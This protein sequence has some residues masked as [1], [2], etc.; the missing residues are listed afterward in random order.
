MQAIGSLFVSYA[1]LLA[2]VPA[3]RAQNGPE[4]GGHE[5][6][7]WTT[8]GHGTNGITQHTGVWTAGFRYGWILTEPH[9]PGILR[10]RFEFAVDAVP[11]FV[12]FQ[13]ANTAYGAGINPFALKWNFDSHGRI[14]PYAELGG[15]VLFTNVQVPSGTSTINF[16]PAGA[17][18]VH[19]LA[20]KLTWSADLRFMHISNAGMQPANPG[21]NTVQ[22]RL[23]IGGFT[24][25]HE[26]KTSGN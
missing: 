19:Y 8:G 3:A 7:I 24:R 18:G 2:A 20:H 1:L 5:I 6:Q 22:L 15:G 16:T 11:V 12:V 23:G 4:A 17:V 21:I 10:G 14:V 9:G 25:G 26:T 13:P